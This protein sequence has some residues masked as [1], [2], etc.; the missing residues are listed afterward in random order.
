MI[1]TH[2]GDAYGGSSLKI[3]GCGRGFRAANATI[4]FVNIDAKIEIL[5]LFTK[6]PSFPSKGFRWRKEKN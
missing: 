3:T 5:T 6:L 4:L 2:F 1:A